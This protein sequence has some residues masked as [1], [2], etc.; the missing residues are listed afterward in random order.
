MPDVIE[1][2]KTVNNGSIKTF[3][4]LQNTIAGNPSGPGLD[5]N[6]SVSTTSLIKF[7]L[8]CIVPKST[9]ELMLSISA[10]NLGDNHKNKYH[11]CQFKFCNN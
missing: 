3:I 4:H 10:N 9:D 6:L 2:L 11:L 5:S 8:I 7:L 1:V